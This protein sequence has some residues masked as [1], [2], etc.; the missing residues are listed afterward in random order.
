MK[1]SVGGDPSSLRESSQIIDR[2]S[3]QTILV[4][5][6]RVFADDH[7]LYAFDIS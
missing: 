2:E 1:C 5:E 7:F 3:S 4:Y 6:Q